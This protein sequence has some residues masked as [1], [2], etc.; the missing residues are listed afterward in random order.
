MIQS[1][2]FALGYITN[3][4]SSSPSGTVFTRW[5]SRWISAA[6]LVQKRPKLMNK[7][8]QIDR[9]QSKTSLGSLNKSKRSRKQDKIQKTP[10]NQNTWTWNKDEL[11]LRQ[12][13]WI[14]DW[15]GENKEAQVRTNQEEAQ[16]IQHLHSPYN[17][18]CD[19]ENYTLSILDCYKNVLVQHDRHRRKGHR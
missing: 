5:L 19:R 17:S 14:H 15:G 7:S 13:D 11:T 18:V 10:G 9:L 2:A 1:S 8:L 16:L 6:V 3:L 4:S 12:T